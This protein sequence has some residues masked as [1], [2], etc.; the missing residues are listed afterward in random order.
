[1]AKSIHLDLFHGDG[2]GPELQ[3]ICW[4]EDGRGL[5]AI[6]YFTDDVAYE[7]E[8]LRHVTFT[9]LQVVMFTPEEVINSGIVP[10]E[11][12]TPRAAMFDLG[13]DAWF[14]SFN[15]QHLADCSHYRL[16]FYDE[17]LDVI[18]T[19]VDCWRGGFGDAV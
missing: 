9:G 18:C 13:Q 1:M 16:E 19:R 11:A 12:R 3:R 2:R 10:A 6:D 17:Y 15:P 5:R 4:T 7:P 14:Q 8:N